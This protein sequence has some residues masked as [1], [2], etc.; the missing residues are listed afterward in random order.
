MFRSLPLSLFAVGLLWSTAALAQPETSRPC[1]GNVQPRHARQIQA[2]NW[3]VG[4]ECMDR[5]FTVYRHWRQHLG[6]LGAKQARIQAGWA[7]TEKEEGKYDW[8]WLDEII[9]DMVTQG[10]EPWVCLCY[11][12]P[13]YPGGGG[14]G[15]GGGLP[16]S[17]EALEAWDRFVSAFVARYERQVRQWEIWNEPR[18]GRGRGA[19]QYAHLVLRTAEAVRARQP[20]ARIIIAAGGA[21]DVEFAQQVLTWLRDQNK[22]SLVDEVTYHPYSA[23]PDASYDTV[24]RLRRAVASL[25]QKIGLRQGENGCPSQPGGFG[26]LR[27]LPWT[28][29]SQAKWALRRLL[30][31]LGRD[32]PSSYFSICDLHYPDRINYKGLLATNP[33]KT[34]HHLKPAYRAVQHVTAVFDANLRRIK[35]FSCTISGGAEESRWSAFGYTS[36]AG[37]LI[38]LWRSSDVPGKRPDMEYVQVILPQVDF[39][40]PVWV[41]MLSGKVCAFASSE[42]RKQGAATVFDRVAAYDSVIL[43]AERRTIPLAE[44]TSG[45]GKPGR[46]TGDP[47][48]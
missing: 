15:L 31:D 30:G 8:A 37:N 33:D 4:A 19:L 5:D 47:S 22:L 10:V 28:E 36:K 7:K 35:D 48:R 6:L 24:E 32:I 14:T 18:G 9:P 12:N 38:T 21:F 46:A 23:N 1:L 40:E 11:G 20:D 39:Q 45:A 27:D 43:I 26:A 13:V 16:E 17:P 41:D 3:A 25:S 44:P 29:T 42:W 34:V 2:S